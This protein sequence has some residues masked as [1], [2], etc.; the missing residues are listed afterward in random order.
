M[1]A[2][3]ARNKVTIA[4]AAAV[5]F[6]S[7]IAYLAIVAPKRSRASDLE[8]RVATTRVDLA[9]ARIEEA[10]TKTTPE[11]PVADLSRLT[12]AMPDQ[13][14]MP[15]LLL[16]LARVAHETGISFDSITPAEP[17][18]ATGYQKIPVS[19]VF[20]GNFFELSDFLFRLRNLVDVRDNRLRVD[21]RLFSIDGIDF[22][23]GTQ[24]FPQ[25]QATLN[26]SA[27]TYGGAPAATP[28]ATTPPAETSGPSAAGAP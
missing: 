23:Q 25:I 16:E 4:A 6:L 8:E 11:V 14:D 27:F 3:L 20:Q 19:L 26:A 15:G 5:V 17:V 9:E 24:Q 12:K 28:P 18:A 1:T 7:L 2:K 13:T 10:R 21:G 22:A